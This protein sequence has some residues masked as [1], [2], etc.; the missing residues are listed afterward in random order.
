MNTTTKLPTIR[1]FK[2]TSLCALR[3]ANA[4]VPLTMEWHEARRVT[5]PTGMKGL[6]GKGRVVFADGT[7]GRFTATLDD[8]GL[9]VR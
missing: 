5:Y 3:N 4:G 7:Y 8:A 2:A 1:Q 6:R 9:M